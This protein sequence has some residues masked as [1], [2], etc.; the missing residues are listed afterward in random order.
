[1]T[2]T[3][4]F[5]ST[6]ELRRSSNGEIFK[7]Y[8]VW[9]NDDLKGYYCSFLELFM[10][11]FDW[12]PSFVTSK[13]NSVCERERKLALQTGESVCKRVCVFSLSVWKFRGRSLLLFPPSALPGHKRGRPQ[14]PAFRRGLPFC[15]RNHYS[16]CSELAGQ[17]HP[18]HLPD[19]GRAFLPTTM[20]RPLW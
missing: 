9:D 17:A 12:L 13:L 18:S 19:A 7:L 14:P 10:K 20:R 6:I 16:I 4:V 1:M 8:N 11:R 2:T 15:K 3:K 5:S